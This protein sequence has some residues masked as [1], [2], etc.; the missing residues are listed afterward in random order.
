MNISMDE[1]FHTYT[2]NQ[3]DLKMINVTL[4]GPRKHFSCNKKMKMF[5]PFLLLIFLNR[6][7]LRNWKSLYSNIQFLSLLLLLPLMDI[8]QNLLQKSLLMSIYDCISYYT[9]DFQIDFLYIPT[10]T[11]IKDI[12]DKQKKDIHLLF[13]E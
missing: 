7:P 4:T 1:L 6:I 5:L 11:C 2:S 10:L 3:K 8:A 12:S 9:L 13:F